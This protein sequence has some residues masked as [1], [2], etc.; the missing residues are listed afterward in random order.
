[1]MLGT[2]ASTS[3]NEVSGRRSRAGAYSVTNS[4]V[5][6]ETGTAITERDHRDEDRA[7]QRG[8][9]AELPE[10]RLPDGRREEAE[11]GDSQR[12]PRADERNSPISTMSASVSA[13]L[14][15]HDA[16]VKA[17]RG[18]AAERRAA[19]AARRT[20]STVRSRGRTRL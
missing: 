16:A 5:Q 6:I 12:V 8:P 17:V 11:P 18:R 9:H 10:L 3:T 15:A 13:P 19:L 2:A 14:A 20:E 7:E 4:A 1:M